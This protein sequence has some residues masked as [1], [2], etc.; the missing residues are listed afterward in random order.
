[1]CLYNKNNKKINKTSK[2]NN[3]DMHSQNHNGTL[4]RGHENPHLYRML[5]GNSNS[6][7]SLERNDVSTIEYEVSMPVNP[8]H[9]LWNLHQ[10]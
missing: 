1:M 7:P 4:P 9:S 6:H 10:W 2:M 5:R 3:S 8:Y